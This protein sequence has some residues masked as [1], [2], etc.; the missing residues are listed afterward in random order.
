M[1]KLSIS[2]IKQFNKKAMDILMSIPTPEGFTRS[3]KISADEVE[4]EFLSEDVKIRLDHYKTDES[5]P[6]YVYNVA[7]GH[8]SFKTSKGWLTFDRLGI[9]DSFYLD[10]DTTL[11]SATQK[12]REEITRARAQ[13]THHLN[14][15][16]LPGIRFTCLKTPEQIEEIRQKLKAGKSVTLTPG[17]MGQGIYLSTRKPRARYGVTEASPELKK[18]LGAN[19]LYLESFDHD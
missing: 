14:T 2:E 8:T 12:V 19:T 15:V 7:G 9:S 4:V 6:G 17:G 3:E 18:L 16:Q 10:D 13:I 1:P 11:E 5:E